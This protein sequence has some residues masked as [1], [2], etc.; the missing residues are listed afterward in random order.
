MSFATRLQSGHWSHLQLAAN[1]SGNT[2]W[3][4]LPTSATPTS[5]L[6]TGTWKP[7]P[8][9]YSTSPSSLRTLCREGGHDFPRTA[10]GSIPPR[11]SCPPPWRQPTHLRFVRLQ[12]PVFVRV[13]LEETQS[14][15]FGSDA[16]AVGRSADLHIPGTSGD[17]TWQ[18][19]GDANHPLG[20]HPVV[21]PLSA[22]PGASR[23]R[24]GAPR[25]GDPLQENRHP[26]GASSGP[27]RNA[28]PARPSR[29]I[30]AGGGSRSSP[31]AI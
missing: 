24:A 1:E 28:G 30:Y 22:A 14:G 27:G 23:G 5:M 16:G 18:F 13:C 15:A 4:W 29:S 25:S 26:A 10:H 8:S 3:P 9:F 2:C 11:A 20:C 6:P 21:L 19:S 7:R 12:L 31:A 17:H